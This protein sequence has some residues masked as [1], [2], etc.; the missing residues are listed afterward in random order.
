MPFKLRKPSIEDNITVQILN[1]KAS[2]PA[3]PKIGDIYIEDNGI[4]YLFIDNAWIEVADGVD[5]TV[6]CHAVTPNNFIYYGRHSAAGHNVSP[7]LYIKASLPPLY[8][9]EE[10]L[11]NIYDNEPDIDWENFAAQVRKDAEKFLNKEHRESKVNIIQPKKRKLD[12][13]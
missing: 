3:K 1:W 5:I 11:K 10:V 2:R 4:T 6:T 8:N 7:S 9:P 13:E 12:I